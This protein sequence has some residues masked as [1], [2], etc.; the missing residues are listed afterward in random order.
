MT[1][2]R[3]QAATF[4]ALA[5]LRMDR[6]WPSSACISGPHGEVGLAPPSSASMPDQSPEANA[7]S[8]LI[9]NVGSTPGML[10]VDLDLQDLVS[11]LPLAQSRL[12]RLFDFALRRYSE[13]LE[14]LPELEIEDVLIHGYL[15]LII[16]PIGSATSDPAAPRP[17]M[18]SADRLAGEA[19]S[20][21]WSPKLAP[22]PA[23]AEQ[24]C[25]QRYSLAS[26]WPQR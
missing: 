18:R 19:P 20:P 16:S 23:T 10:S 6:A 25:V 24:S 9:S 12:H 26:K 22:F 1:R 5:A 14:E 15:R 11:S 2:G 21:T 7:I 8:P 4:T 13:A 17:E 3:L